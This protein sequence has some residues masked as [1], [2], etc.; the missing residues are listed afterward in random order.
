MIRSFLIFHLFFTASMLLAGNGSEND[1]LIKAL[2]LAKVD[3]QKVNILYDLS[4]NQDEP[5]T[6]KKYAEELLALSL[7]INYVKGITLGYNLL[8]NIQKSQGNF[9]EA[10]EL[11]M[12]AL[13]I[14]EKEKDSLGIAKVNNN[15]GEEYRLLG[16]HTKALE[17]Y[18][19]SLKILEKM[20]KQKLVAISLSN[21]AIIYRQQKNPD[22]ARAS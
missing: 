3:T 19:R 16:E 11:H 15:L 22:K 1:S 6:A 14:L 9:R 10:L 7:K 13:N 17:H 4:I 8:G 12:K 20:D 18:F 5:V 21:I 2:G